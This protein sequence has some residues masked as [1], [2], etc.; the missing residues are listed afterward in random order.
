MKRSMLA[1]LFL[2]APIVLTGLAVAPWPVT[3]PAITQAQLISCGGQPRG[4][5]DGVYRAYG[6]SSPSN[7]L[8][9][10]TS[11]ELAWATGTPLDC[12]ADADKYMEFQ[13]GSIY[14]NRV[15]HTA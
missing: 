4:A 6:G 10:A 2:I 3:V 7:P 11:E 12:G 14:F 1:R 13:H 9:N 15:E 5:I 8:G